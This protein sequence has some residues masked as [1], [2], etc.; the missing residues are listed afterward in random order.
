MMNA[1]FELSEKYLCPIFIVALAAAGVLRPFV[2]VF[3]SIL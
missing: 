2:T 3:M 1:F